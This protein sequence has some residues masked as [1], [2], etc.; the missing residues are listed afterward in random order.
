[1]VAHR[2]NPT[3]NSCHGIIDPI[4]FSLENFN[5]I[6]QWRDKDRETGTLIEA[7]DTIHGEKVTGPD[8]LRKLI[9]RKPDQFVQTLTIKLMTYALGRGVEAHDMPTVRAI[10]RDAAKN[11]NKM[12]AFVLGVV[13]SAA[14]RMAKPES[15]TKTLNTDVAEKQ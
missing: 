8:D 15:Q 9:L 4:G 10:V 13:N 5:A 14:F 1:M 3:C 6:G 11:G 7:S 12:S 2:A